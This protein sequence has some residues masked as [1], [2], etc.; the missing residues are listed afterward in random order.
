LAAGLE[1]RKLAD[2]RVLVRGWIEERGGPQIEASR[3]EQI[4]F[5]EGDK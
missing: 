1:P 5:I 3:P 4:E 2:R